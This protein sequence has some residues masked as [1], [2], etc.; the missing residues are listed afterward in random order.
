MAFWKNSLSKVW[1]WKALLLLH[2][3]NP[4]VSSAEWSQAIS[5]LSR[6]HTVYTVD[7]LGCGLSDKPNLTYTN[8]LYVQMISDFIKHIIHEPADVIASGSAAPLVAM[9]AT[10]GQE[11][12]DKMIFV[13][14]QNLHDLAKIPSKRSKLLYHLVS[15]P[16]VGTF[17]Y[18]I[19][20]C[21]KRIA[22]K[23]RES[24]YDPSQMMIFWSIHILNPL[25]WT[26]C[27]PDIFSP[28]S[29]EIIQRLILHLFCQRLR[30]VSLS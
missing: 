10:A 14:P 7:L 17:L 9:T 30:T 4:A 25:I 28:A 20:F 29:A 26:R 22:L 24:F 13:N 6:E 3:L 27:I 16:L 12:I 18:N 21:R 19:L 23:L 1:M 2:D 8:F 11:L 15:M 5:L